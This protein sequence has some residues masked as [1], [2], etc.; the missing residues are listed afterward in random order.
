ME[1][2]IKGTRVIDL[3][4]TLEP[5]IPKPIGFPDPKSEFFSSIA[6]G[7]VI[8]AEKLSFCPHS[9]TH[10]DAPYHFFNDL[11]TIDEMPP[12][13]ILGPAVVI[14][15]RYKKHGFD[16]IERSEIEEWEKNNGETIRKGDAVL[17]MTGFSKLWKKGKEGE[18]FL[19]N[20]WP[21]IT[22]SVADYF[23]EKS[24]RLIGVE[25]MD[26]DLIDP[27]DLAK[28]EFIGHKTFLS[29]GI[30]IIENLTNLDKIG[31]TRCSIIATPLKIKGGTGSP[32]RLIAIV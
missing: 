17:L 18:K 14:D 9:G 4:Q 23:V 32:I 8:N 5:D 31:S 29:K 30:Y 16:P 27:Y 10:I 19:T 6:E 22:K 11:I 3:S 26:L 15:L 1:I 25:S 24:I 21:Y 12:E 20:G 28:A 13:C 7:K 2:N